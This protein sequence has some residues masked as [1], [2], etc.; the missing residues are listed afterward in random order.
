MQRQ[1]FARRPHG[2]LEIDICFE[3]HCLWLDQYEASQ[4]TP[5]AVMELFRTIHAKASEHA[6]PV[7]THARCPKCQGA[8]VFTNDYQGSNRINYYRCPQWH[9]RLTTF[10]QFLREKHFVRDLT[11]AEIAGLR[12]RMEQVRCSSCGGAIDI[13]RDAACGYCRAPLAIL[14]A[15]AVERTL[16][17]LSD[18][19]RRRQVVD[20]SA[21]IEALLAGQRIERRLARIETGATLPAFDL[22]QEALHRLMSD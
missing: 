20:P 5:G 11:P 8:L 14:D 22:V 2:T 7:A 4:L 6:K 15:D 12:V 16:R 3:C 1:V 18:E 21:A 13:G 17:E 19:E 10:F 9:G